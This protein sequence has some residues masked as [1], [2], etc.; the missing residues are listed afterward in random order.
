M[1]RYIDAEA[2][3]KD[4]HDFQ[5]S[6]NEWYAEAEDEDIKHR[7]ESAIIT[8]AEAKLRLKKQPTV[9]AVPVV[10]CK[11]CKHWNPNGIGICKLHDIRPTPLMMD[12]WF[13]A[14]GKAK[15]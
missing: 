7:A 12:N 4:M 13:C 10:R 6:L 3:E 8:L 14:D 1:S 9:D 5:T 15:V 2:Y 11:D